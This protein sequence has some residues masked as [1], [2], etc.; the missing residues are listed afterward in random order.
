M[1]AMSV[2]I[3]MSSHHQRNNQSPPS[4]SNTADDPSSI[5]PPLNLGGG[6]SQ[7]SNGGGG[8]DYGIYQ[9]H[10]LGDLQDFSGG[11]DDSRI[12]GGSAFAHTPTGSGP[13]LGL[14][15][16]SSTSAVRS[17]NVTESVTV[18]TSE[19]VAEI[20]GRQGCK[21]KALRAKTGTYI[22]TPVRG[23]EPTFVVTGKPGDVEHAKRE[24]LS[25]ADHFSNIR[26]SRSQQRSQGGGLNGGGAGASSNGVGGGGGGSSLGGSSMPPGLRGPG[27]GGVGVEPG[28]PMRQSSTSGADTVTITVKVPYNVVG[29]VVGPRGA[30]IK[31]IQ[32]MTGTYIVTPSREKD[33]V[34]EIQGSRENV[35]KARQEISGYITHRT[36]YGSDA[37]AGAPMGYLDDED[38]RSMRLETEYLAQPDG[39]TGSLADAVNNTIS[40]PLT[41]T[42]NIWSSR[43]SDWPPRNI[44]G[45][46]GGGVGSGAGGSGAGGNHMAFRQFG[47]SSSSGQ[48]GGGGG[49]G[50][51]SSG[52]SRPATGSPFDFSQ[53]SEVLG[54]MSAAGG[55]HAP[56]MMTR[57]EPIG[58]RGQTYGM[59]F[60][61]GSGGVNGGNGSA[62]ASSTSINSPVSTGGS[63]GVGSGSLLSS[64][65]GAIGN[66][67]SD[68][69]SLSA[70]TSTSGGLTDNS[71]PQSGSNSGGS[72]PALPGGARGS[73]SACGNECSSC[74]RVRETDVA[75]VPCGHNLFCQECAMS[76]VENQQPCPACKQMPTQALRLR[77]Q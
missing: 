52:S 27:G 22:K 16:Q 30:T 46:G 66:A 10:D 68:S 60:G 45:G 62:F 15:R 1:Q 44:G 19:H 58:S 12:G 73:V 59:K 39:L 57:S 17:N 11:Y 72:T 63:S 35:E 47:V 8:G 23:E 13:Q 24:I 53:T 26:A 5:W 32:S 33:P 25:A 69:G 43:A 14:Q 64:Y 61:G 29:L 56:L 74:G 71:G 20:V 40:H 18:P 51:R 67:P 38:H 50:R 6:G 49:G 54:S 41:P 70:A 77:T 65:F 28:I 76:F 7:F 2:A 75:L 31:K 55:N 9:G 48:G 21:I 42:T 36:R 34:F 4:F 37:D 3:G